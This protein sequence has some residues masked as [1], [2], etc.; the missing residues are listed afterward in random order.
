MKSCSPGGTA[1]TAPLPRKNASQPRAGS[2]VP[3]GT[4]GRTCASSARSICAT[5]GSGRPSLPR[6]HGAGPRRG[7]P[8]S[9]LVSASQSW[10]RSR[11]RRTSR[12]G[13]GGGGRSGSGA[14][15]S[16]SAAMS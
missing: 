14:G 6:G 1:T 16:S 3:S 5:K 2:P 12:I 8:P 15:G 7:S 13:A 11:G 10:P 4:S 9:Q